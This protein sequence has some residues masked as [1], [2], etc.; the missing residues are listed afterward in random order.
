MSIYKVFPLLL[1]LSAQA[2]AADLLLPALSYR[3]ETD[4]A[5]GGF[6]L[7]TFR[8]R[9][10]LEDSRPSS[11][12]LVGLM[13]LRGQWG[14]QLFPEL[15]LSDEKYR[16]NGE[17]GYYSLPDRFYG[18]GTDTSPSLYT[19]FATQ[20][21]RFRLI[22]RRQWDKK[23]GVGPVIEFEQRINQLRTTGELLGVNE[24]RTLGLGVIL[25][26]DTR[27]SIFFPKQGEFLEWSALMHS[28]A[29]VSQFSFS[30]F[31]LDLRK[32]F[33]YD[34][35]E[36]VLA[37]QH[38]MQWTLGDV[39]FTSLTTL[40]GSRV[41]RGY[42]EGRFRDRIGWATQAEYRFIVWQKIGAAVFGSLGSVAN[43]FDQITKKNNSFCW[44]WN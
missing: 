44:I 5:F 15:Y 34:F 7:K 26:Y 23:I 39:P 2:I 20:F 28:E 31:R 12:R 36:S 22:A 3:P 37:V 13:S 43:T 9:D 19:G 11:Y 25:S 29:F 6:Y 38:W 21:P 8:L 33:S 41:L 40:G 42:W 30:R 17:L 10:E 32:Y 1:L 27:D 35:L 16:I 24:A 4:W 18:L 14:V